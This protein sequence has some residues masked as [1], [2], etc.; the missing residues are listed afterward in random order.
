M[1]NRLTT[2]AKTL[3]LI[4][5][6]AVFIAGMWLLL[7]LILSWALAPLIYLL[8]LLTYTIP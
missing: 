7:G 5:A 6:L 4:T 8:A 3:A 2:L 1:K